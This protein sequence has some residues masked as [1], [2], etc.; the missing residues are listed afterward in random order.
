MNCVNCKHLAKQY[1]MHF[2]HHPNIKEA[3]EKY[4]QNSSKTSI[5][6]YVGYIGKNI[7]NRLPLKYCPLKENK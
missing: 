4:T 3:A 1:N 6:R 5:I 7:K 2:C